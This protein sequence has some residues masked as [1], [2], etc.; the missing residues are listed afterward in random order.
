MELIKIP[1]TPL[2]VIVGSWQADIFSRSFICNYLFPG[3]S[4]IIEDAPPFPNVS[5]AFGLDDY[6][7]QVQN[8][9]IVFVIIKHSPSIENEIVKRARM[10]LELLPFTPLRAFGVNWILRLQSINNELFNKYRLLIDN[11][12]SQEYTAQNLTG[13]INLTKE[14]YALNIKIN[15]IGIEFIA[16]IN[17]EYQAM[18][19]TAVLSLLTPSLIFERENEITD[20]IKTRLS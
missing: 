15:I 3:E 4:P 13:L 6:R 16:D 19:T 1:N 10:I 2:L 17:F 20:L 5:M 9:R 18:D 14:N 12:S 11:L 8:D 7:I